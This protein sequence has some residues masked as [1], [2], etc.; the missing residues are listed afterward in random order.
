MNGYNCSFAF[1]IAAELSRFC[2]KMNSFCLSGLTISK[3]SLYLLDLFD[4]VKRLQFPLPE[5]NAG[6][7]PG[8]SLMMAFSNILIILDSFASTGVAPQ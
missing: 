1:Y 4:L 5:D 2:P 7:R 6:K 3:Q 8:P